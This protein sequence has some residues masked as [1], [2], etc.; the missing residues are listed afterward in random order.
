MVFHGKND[1]LIPYNHSNTIVNVIHQKKPHLKAKKFLIDGVGHNDVNIQFIGLRIFMQYQN[2]LQSS[3]QEES[4]SMNID[5]LVRYLDN[6]PQFDVMSN[7]VQNF[8]A[9]PYEIQRK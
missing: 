6:P 3:F 7:H 8:N 9:F 1:E 5:K 4:L 2:E